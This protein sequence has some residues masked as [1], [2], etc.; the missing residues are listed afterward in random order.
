MVRN[1]RSRSPL[2]SEMKGDVSPKG[3]SVQ[4]GEN[5]EGSSVKTI[6]ERVLSSQSNYTR[7]VRDDS[8]QGIALNGDLGNLEV[9]FSML[10]P[11]QSDG[12]PQTDGKH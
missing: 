3:I 11:K 8:I 12:V 6:K 10:S 4:R 1:G 5:I 9:K 7:A 2:G